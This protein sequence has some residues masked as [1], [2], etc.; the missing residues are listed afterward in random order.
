MDNDKVA[1]V[2][3]AGKGMG[4]AIAEEGDREVFLN[5]LAR[6]PWFGLEE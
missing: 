1:I 6:Q 2:T 4:A 3:A 5:E